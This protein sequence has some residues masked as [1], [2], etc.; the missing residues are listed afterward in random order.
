MS[1]LVNSINIAPVAYGYCSYDGNSANLYNC[2]VSASNNVYTINITSGTYPY[3]V[4][5][6]SCEF[7][8]CLVAISSKSSNQVVFRTHYSAGSNSGS[9]ASFNFVIFG[10]T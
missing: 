8:N 7:S 1:Y 2:T 5:I 10:H 3:I 6:A 4:P 9:S